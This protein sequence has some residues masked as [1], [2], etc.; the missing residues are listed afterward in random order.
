MKR[1]WDLRLARLSPS[2]FNKLLFIVFYIQCLHK[3]M[4][5]DLLNKYKIYIFNCL[6]FIFKCLKSNMFP[7][8]RNKITQNLNIHNHNTRNRSMYRAQENVRL[9][10]CQR[11]AVHKGITIWNS[12]GNEQKQH[13]TVQSFKKSMKDHL[14][15]LWFDVYTNNYLFSKLILIIIF[16]RNIMA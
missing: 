3:T 2:L 5:N 1:S 8:F 10:I 12:L 6:L 15:N 7:L 9:R 13:N 16:F 14:I 4:N 11:S